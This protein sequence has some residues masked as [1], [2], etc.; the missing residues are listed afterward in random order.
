MMDENQSPD[1]AVKWR[2]WAEITMW[3]GYVK[4]KKPLFVKY[5]N[6]T[7]REIGDTKK[8]IETQNNVRSRK[9]LWGKHAFGYW[10]M[11]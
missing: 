3:N 6:K 10:Q 8:K 2:P 5:S 1:V 7:R 11:C 4:A 9:I